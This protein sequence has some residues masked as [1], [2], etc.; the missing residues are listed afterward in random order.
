MRKMEENDPSSRTSG[1][2][3][4]SRSKLL[5]ILLAIIIIS[6][7][8]AFEWTVN[9]T[10]PQP[11]STFDKKD[12]R[13]APD[14]PKEDALNHRGGTNVT[15]DD[16]NEDDEVSPPSD[17]NN[18]NDVV[19]TNT[20]DESSVVDDEISPSSDSINHTD[21]EQNISADDNSA[22]IDDITPPSDPVNFADTMQTNVV[23]NS[24][25]VDN[26]TGQINSTDDTP[27]VDN[28]SAP[29]SDPADCADT[30]QMNSVE[31]NSTV[32]N[33][34][35]QPSDMGN[36]SDTVQTNI[37]D[38]TPTVGNDTAPTSDQANYTHKGS[39]TIIFRI[40]SSGNSY[41]NYKVYFNG[42]VWLNYSIYNETYIPVGRDVY[43]PIQYEWGYDTTNATVLA[44]HCDFIH[45]SNPWTVWG[46]DGWWGY[47]YETTLSVQDGGT[48]QIIIDDI[49]YTSYSDYMASW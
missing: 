30:G 20:G 4:L 40:I 42:I 16:S 36:C 24:P 14:E 43:V 39:V 33:D 2:K 35:A 23:D 26:D 11:S 31:D 5:S 34:T 13:N 46:P 49:M 12:D 19:Q 21:I 9:N 38:D 3:L 45:G 37:T 1:S 41:Q 8:F 18:C 47:D 22:V 25:T 28:N 44:L 32:D 15:D 17:S 6:S 27:A 7:V 10:Q 48:Y 29:S